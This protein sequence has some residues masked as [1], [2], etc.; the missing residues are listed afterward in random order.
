M[1]LDCTWEGIQTKSH[2]NLDRIFSRTPNRNLRRIS[3]ES[4]GG[5]WHN[6]TESSEGFQQNPQRNSGR[7]LREIPKESLEWLQQNSQ[8]DFDRV[9]RRIPPESSDRCFQNHQTKYPRRFQQP[10]YEE[11][12]ESSEG[13]LRNPEEVDSIRI[14]FMVST[15]IILLEFSAEVDWNSLYLQNG[16]ENVYNKVIIIMIKTMDFLRFSNV[17]HSILK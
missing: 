7:M 17:F 9:I 2:E 8:E 5:F 12:Q 4:S 10:L 14:L 16:S 15:L 3:T 13:F 6:P 1:D 11:F